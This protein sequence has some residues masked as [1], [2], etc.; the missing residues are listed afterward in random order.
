MTNRLASFQKALLLS[1]VRSEIRGSV[2]ALFVFAEQS[3]RAI[4]ASLNNNDWWVEFWE[5]EE[6][7][8]PIREQTFS[9]DAEAHRAAAM[10]LTS[11][12]DS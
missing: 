6:D 4:E 11:P 12:P 5:A 3:G 10:W 2:T 9:E 7:A 1:G 8:P